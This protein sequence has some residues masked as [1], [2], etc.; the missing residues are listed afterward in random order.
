VS[1]PEEDSDVKGDSQ[2]KR[3]ANF[4]ASVVPNLGQSIQLLMRMVE[5]SDLMEF[6]LLQLEVVDHLEKMVDVL[7]AKRT[8]D[9][10]L[11]DPLIPQ[12]TQLAQDLT[13]TISV[14]LETTAQMDNVSKTRVEIL[15]ASVTLDSKRMETIIAQI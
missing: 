2:Q 15:Y 1:T 6:Q 12:L 5:R 13:V 10:F 9:L 8:A 14:M 4:S 3:I 7:A 11:L